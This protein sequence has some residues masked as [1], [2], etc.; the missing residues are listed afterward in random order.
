MN[1]ILPV[2]LLILVIII[3]LSLVFGGLILDRRLSLFQS[4][5]LKLRDE[6]FADAAKGLI[7]FNDPAYILLHTAMTDFLRYS[8]SLIKVIYL[9]KNKEFNYSVI[10]HFEKDWA[11]ALDKLSEEKQ[12]KMSQYRRSIDTLLK[13][14]LFNFTPGKTWVAVVVD[15]KQVYLGQKL[16]SNASSN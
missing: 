13:K 6:L 16:H 11:I 15:N 3:V 2:S 5:M 8:N 4:E 7:Q 12:E 14:L 1:E 9:L 10:N